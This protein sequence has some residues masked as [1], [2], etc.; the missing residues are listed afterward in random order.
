M[1]SESHQKHVKMIIFLC[2]IDVSCVGTD[3][4]S[5]SQKLS[6]KL[7]ISFMHIWDMTPSA[8]NQQGRIMISSC[9]YTFF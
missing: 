6:V 5:H 7:L 2:L 8:I 1:H 4:V 3:K 9:C